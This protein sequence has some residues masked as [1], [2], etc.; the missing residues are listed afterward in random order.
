MIA[1]LTGLI[2]EVGE[3]WIILDVRGVGYLIFCS[4]KTIEQAPKKFSEYSLFIETHIR[5]D[6]FHLYGFNDLIEQQWFKILISVQG[7]G[8]KVAL[9]IQSLY[10]PNILSKLISNQDKSAFTKVSGIGPKLALRIVNELKDKVPSSLMIEPK[11][12]EYS[13]PNDREDRINA[14]SALINLGFRKT[15]IDQ[16][17]VSLISEQKEIG[18]EDLIRESLKR[19]NKRRELI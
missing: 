7:V 5:E 15:D 14:E 3:G 16:V 1:K 9:A 17:L 4:Q 18:L 13:L 12:N 10:E 2:D 11:L 19:L 8:A 6:H